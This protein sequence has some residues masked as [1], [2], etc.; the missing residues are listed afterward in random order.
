MTS[1]ARLDW[2]PASGL[3]VGRPED[4]A[5][6]AALAFVGEGTRIRRVHGLPA[7]DVPRAARFLDRPDLVAFTSEARRAVSNRATAATVHEAVRQEAERLR[8]QDAPSLRDRLAGNRLIDRLD[9]HQVLNVAIM[10]I[11]GALGA[12][13]FDEQGTGKTVTLIA[14]F[15]QLVERRE[16][17]TL[18][19]VAPKSMVAEWAAEFARF[20]G[21]LYAVRV[22]DGDRAVKAASL[23]DGSD[24]YVTN[25]ETTV[26]MAA[27][28]RALARRRRV[29]LAVDESFAVK[30]PS[31]QR[32]GAVAAL[33][34]WCSRA[35]VLCGTPAPNCAADLVA[36]FDLV[37]FGQTFRHLDQ[38]ARQE[39][40][41]VARTLRR[42][43][44]LRNLKSDVLDL[45]GRTF[46]TVHVQLAPQQRELYLDEL[47]SLAG[48]VAACDEAA[49][50]RDR[51]AYFARRARLLRLCTD[52]S[53]VVVGYDEQPGKAAALDLFIADRVRRQKVLLWSFYRSSLDRYAAAYAHYGLVRVDGSVSSV[54]ERRAAVRAFQQDDDVRIFLGNPAA[55][56]AGLT[57]HAAHV[58]V[59]ES[60]S[61]QAAHYFQSLDR[62]HRRGQTQ[63]VEYVFLVAAD[64]LEELEYARLQDKSTQQGDLLGDTVDVP[65]TRELF[66]HEL[67]EARRLLDGTTTRR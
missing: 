27:D 22:L 64:T 35:Y 59:Y 3:V 32:T 13:V 33:R 12:C 16:V 2:D 25:Y 15:D 47:A 4:A 19:I 8:Q 62:I 48:D 17:D 30:N 40:D 60:V 50:V 57:L 55:A 54:A 52:P 5:R 61:N 39:P 9:P 24:V 20:T 31:S 65:V 10:T 44:Y 36:Q 1:M 37:D 46:T 42:A 6:L 56:G 29:A 38:A 14:A 21:D 26:T 67:L 63:P 11:P 28:L 58:A 53:P 34:E 49:F 7:I 45:P 18:L 66:L 43:V 23:H 51:V 41:Q